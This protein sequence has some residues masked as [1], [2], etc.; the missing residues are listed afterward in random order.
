MDFR[1]PPINHIFQGFQI[2]S[3]LPRHVV[4]LAVVCLAHIFTGITSTEEVHMQYL[5]S[6]GRA[7]KVYLIVLRFP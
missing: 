4:W 5:Y 3:S 7:E 6:S 1:S 2:G